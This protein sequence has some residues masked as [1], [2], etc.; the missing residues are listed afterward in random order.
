MSS[1]NRFLQL[2]CALQWRAALSE[3]GPTGA[4][5]RTTDGG[6]TTMTTTASTRNTRGSGITGGFR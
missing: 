6:G 2:H 4:E 1:R 5:D 3:N